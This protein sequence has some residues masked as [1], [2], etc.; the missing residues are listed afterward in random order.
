MGQSRFWERQGKATE[1]GKKSVSRGPGKEGD[2]AG[3]WVG[4][5]EAAGGG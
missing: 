5:K 2:A 1:G 3:L 4:L